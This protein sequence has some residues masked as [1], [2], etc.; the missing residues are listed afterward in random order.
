MTTKTYAV[1]GMTC[2]HCVNVVTTELEA[3]SGVSTV[4]VDLAAGDV[5]VDAASD[6][7]GVVVAAAIE[8][9]GYTLRA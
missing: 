5:R 8:R 6:V 1:E 2:G 3:V 4:Q 7:D 9:A